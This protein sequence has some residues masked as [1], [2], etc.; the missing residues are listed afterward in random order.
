[1]A[2]LTAVGF[3]LFSAGIPDRPSSSK[4]QPP[5]R[6]IVS[7]KNVLLTTTV[8]KRNDACAARTNLLGLMLPVGY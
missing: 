3:A 7:H 1:M 8:A 6:T 5:V 4:E 2:H